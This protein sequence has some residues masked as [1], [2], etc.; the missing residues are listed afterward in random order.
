MRRILLAL[1]VVV[2]AVVTIPLLASSASA[3]RAN[4]ATGSLTVRRAAATAL[5]PE[6]VD[7]KTA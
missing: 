3:S 2:S 5:V 4:R 7:M 1:V 6:G